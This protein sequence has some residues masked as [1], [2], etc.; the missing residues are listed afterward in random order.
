M[1][2]SQRPS[3]AAARKREATCSA[4]LDATSQLIA[5]KGVDGFTISD[6]AER[7]KVNR[8]LIYHYF[9]NRDNLVFETTRLIADRYDAMRSSPEGDQ[10][11]QSVRMHIE[12]PQIGRFFF[13][14]MLR[15]KPLPKLSRRLTNAI[16]ELDRLKAEHAPGSTLDPT[17]AV[18]SGWLGQL[19]WSCGREEIAR[20][21]GLPVEDADRRFLA[22]MRSMRDTNR[23]LPDAG[24]NAG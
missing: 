13:H 18:I 9:R 5:E 20:L 24:Q 23:R 19:S 11:E 10:L 7:G 14:L 12:H 22:H 8:S 2:V 6:V 15:G 16:A 4:M 1:T 21:L 17:F 3:P